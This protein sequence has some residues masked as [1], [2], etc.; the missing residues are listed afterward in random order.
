MADFC[1]EC[2]DETF[3][4]DCENPISG[5]CKEGEATTILCEGCGEYVWVDYKGKKIRKVELEE[6]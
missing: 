6:K 1:K 3:G 2:H 5:L 4:K